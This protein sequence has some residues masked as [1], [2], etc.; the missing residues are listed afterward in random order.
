[1]KTSRVIQFVAA[2]M[3][4]SGG[5]VALLAHSQFASTICFCFIGVS[6]MRRS[7]L[8]RPVPRR[9]LY[10]GLASLILLVTVVIVLNFVVPRSVGERIVCSPAFVIPF[11]ALLMLV[12]F[13]RWRKERRLTDA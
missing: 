1:M 4:L 11:W 6:L 9:E 2:A 10:V 8:S 12:L 13:W 5:C 7:E 3:L